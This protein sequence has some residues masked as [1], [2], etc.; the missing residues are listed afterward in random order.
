MTEDRPTFAELVD[1][2]EDRLPDDEAQKIANYL[3]TGDEE[4]RKDAAW[5]RAFLAASE[6]ITLDRPPTRVR[7]VLR[8]RFESFA[9]AKRSPGLFQRIRAILT[10][11]S[12]NRPAVAGIRSAATQGMQRQLIF[13]TDIA[14]VALNLQPGAQ[15]KQIEIVGQVFA[16]DRV[17]L[18]ELS[19]QLLRND[20]EVEL[21]G[22]DELGEFTFKGVP[23][24]EY[25]L[26]V[27]AEQFEIVLK[28]VHLQV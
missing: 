13:T 16:P 14:E 25:E 5:I 18:E 17:A 23:A 21:T 11:D 6:S 10:F 4:A 3:E 7:E 20:A 15:D 27:T 26:I 12:G 2:A 8:R 22:A 28:P 9:E 19:I 1:W 24:G